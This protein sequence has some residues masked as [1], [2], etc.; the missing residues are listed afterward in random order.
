[1]KMSV[2]ASGSTGN[3]IYVEHD[4]HKILVD[5]GLTGKK[6]V[7]LMA[8][9]NRK[10]EDLTALLVS[11]EHSDHIKGVGVLARKYQLPIYAN[12]ETWQAMDKLIGNVSNEQKFIFDKGSIKDFGALVVE[13]FGVSHDAVNPQF[14]TFSVDNKKMSIITD[15]GYVS[16]K[17]KGVIYDSDVFVFESNHEEDMLRMCSYPWHTKQRILS[18]QGH[19]SNTDAAYA[20]LDVIGEHTKR[21][22]LAHL[23]KE[24]N[25]K[26][27]ANR[28]AKTIL[29][30][31][32]INIAK[33]QI[34]DT[35]PS[36]AT[37][38][39]EL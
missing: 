24:N 15:T 19:V 11:H 25:L 18:D 20:M 33:V 21:I 8:S 3:A 17:M 36:E 22:Y 37:P 13:S 31:A 28:T 10:P 4:Q 34:H 16:D 12:H 6:I 39:I 26:E 35:D 1:M 27:L 38:L 30:Q 32:D 7:E 23:S 29:T 5:A 2:L 14:Y 9:I